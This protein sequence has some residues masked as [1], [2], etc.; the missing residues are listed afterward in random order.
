MT[1]AEFTR[2]GLESLSH[3][4]YDA[5]IN[6]LRQA[7]GNDQNDQPARFGLAQALHRR[8]NLTEAIYEYQTVLRTEPDHQMALRQLAEVYLLSGKP[9]QAL[10]NL[11]IALRAKPGDPDLLAAHGMAQLELGHHRT[12]LADFHSASRLRPG[13]SMIHHMI[14]LC[15]RAEKDIEGERRALDQLL[16]ITPHSL[17]CLNDIGRLEML[18]GN[19]G[20]ALDY[21]DRALLTMPTSPTALTN[22]AIALTVLG[23]ET[24][25]D[26]WD[27]AIKAD[28]NAPEDGLRNA[29]IAQLH[30][31]AGD[32]LTDGNTGDG[33]VNA[34]SAGQRHYLAS[35]ALAM[36]TI[37]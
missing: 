10:N 17:A 20:S 1:T 14:A 15:Y 18:E 16:R 27:T 26:A 35:G 12:A 24:A 32:L 7:L 33:D 21:F 6:M 30:E 13:D 4:H 23:D 3:G 25:R 34:D 9:R 36:S 37:V 2:M 11:D 28:A 29:A 31:L 8:G 5:A 22:R 19:Y